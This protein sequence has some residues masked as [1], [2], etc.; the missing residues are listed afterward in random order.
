MTTRR[1]AST[2]ALTA[3]PA[4]RVTQAGAGRDLAAAHELLDAR[5]EAAE[6]DEEPVPAGVDDAGLLQGR[7]LGGRVL[8]RDPAGLLDRREQVLE[9]ESVGHG[10]RGRRHL[11]DDGEHGA[12]DGRLDGAVGGV[13]ALEDRPLED[14]GVERVGLTP[15]V[16]D[17]A[18][19]LG[20][21]DAGVAARAHER[22][23]GDGGGHGRDVGDL[24]LLELLDH[25]A[26]GERHVGAG[27]PVRDG[28]HVEVVD[29]LT[30]S[31]DGGERGLDDSDGGGAY[32][33]QSCRSSTRT[34]M[35]PTGTPPTPSTW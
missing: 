17:A 10:L 32:D 29:V 34:L 11:A 6:E 18:H 21:D 35:S 7:Q 2:R 33:A 15:D 12:L 5:G 13:L 23:L 16:A 19:D 1:S 27:V 28:V 8:D 9:P 20:E 26:H 4:A 24:A 25:G 30:L 22:A 31:L 3:S 14:G